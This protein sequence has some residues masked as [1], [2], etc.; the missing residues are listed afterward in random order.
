MAD[1]PDW[2]R[3]LRSF[4]RWHEQGDRGAA[5]YGCAEVERFLRGRL[6]PMV[7]RRWSPDQI[8]DAVQGFL[9]KR[10]ATPLVEAAIE[11]PAAWMRTSFRRWCIDRYRKR[12]EDRTEPLDP[13]AEVGVMTSRPEHRERIARASTALGRLSVADR[14]AIKLVDLPLGL[15]RDELD[16]LARRCGRSADEVRGIALSAPDVFELTFLV[17]PGAVPSDARD[18]RRRMERF[19]KQRNRARQRLREQL[20]EGDG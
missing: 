2:D 9:E 11:C 1:G 6:P 17:D 12:K 14:V 7:A 10:L 18:R 4:Q 20:L 13:T 19:R 3:I 5:E 16:W 15:D 8:D